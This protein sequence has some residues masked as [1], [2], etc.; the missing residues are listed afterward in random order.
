V[1]NS[2]TRTVLWLLG[3]LGAITLLLYLFVFDTWVIPNDDP[4]L[5]ASIQPTLAPEDRILTRRGSTP[6]NGELARCIKPDGSGKFVIG[7]VFGSATGENVELN[8]E[9]VSLN[10]KTLGARF[11]CPSV[12]VTQPATLEKVLLTCSTQDNGAFTYDVLTHPEYREGRHAATLEPGKMFLVSD[13][14]HIH[15]DSRDFGQVDATTC[16]HIVFRLWGESF[17]DGKR[18]F[19]VL[20]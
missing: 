8:D 1:E 15:Q 18:R 19:T 3:I 6:K 7:R 2:T 5:T 12:T 9:R 14:R 17:G 16:E 11:Q 4:A 10:G 20:W 13:D